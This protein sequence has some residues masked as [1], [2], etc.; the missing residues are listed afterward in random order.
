[1]RTINTVEKLKVKNQKLK[2]QNSPSLIPLSILAFCFLN[3]LTGCIQRSEL[4]LAQECVGKSQVYYQH[5][6]ERYKTLISKGKDL[7]RLHFELGRLYFWRGEFD[8]AIQEL[9]K[10]NFIQARKLLAVSYY[11]LADFTDALEVF[12][13]Q[14]TGDEEYLYYYGLTCEKLNL[15]DEALEVYKKIKYK[16][17]L[18]LATSRINIIEKQVGALKIKDIDPRVYNII[19]TAPKQNNYPQAGALIL[20]C[21]EK[22]EI[23]AKDTQISSLHYIVK[24]LNERGKEDFSEAHIE[25]DSTYEK[26]ELEYART[27]KPD[28]TVV[29]VGSRHIRDVSKYL[30]FPLYSN[31]RV[32]I[33]S[34]PEIAESSCID[35]KLKIHRNQ[36]INKKDFIV[37][38]PLE[39]AEPIIDAKFTLDLPASKGLHLKTLNEEYNDFKAKLKPEVKIQG[40]RVIYAWQF[41]DIPQIIPEPNMPA[42]VEINPAILISSFD[43]W[44]EVYQWWLSL[45][46]EKI[47]ADT[48]IKEKV[49]DLIKGKVSQEDKARSIYNFCAKEIRYVA[50]EY[51]Q[52]GY[53]PHQAY[54]IFK[55]KYGDC[56]DQAILLVTMLR[57]AGLKAWPVLISTK[58]YYNLNHDLPA[59]FFNHSIACVQL[60]DK[61]VFLDPTCSTCSFGDLPASDQARQ[62]LVFKEDNY[63]IQNGKFGEDPKWFTLDKGTKQYC[64]GYIEGYEY[65]NQQGGQRRVICGNMV[66]WPEENWGEEVLN[67]TA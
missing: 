67:K 66:V 11:W 60:K 12:S 38:Y 19:Q 47:R 28:G 2:I 36:L 54:D 64:I 62:V 25:Y 1:M 33:I 23:T 9:K 59:V 45:A 18:L 56:K 46:Q 35:Y 31:A 14:D 24:I 10:T 52:A 26:V 51:G 48:A 5:A 27:I 30:N 21:D 13:K 22:V 65:C 7:D 49:K 37:S 32:F 4:E 39:S 34:F 63:E 43:S 3:L 15:F 41:K 61:I 16:D 44:K 42:S 8:K 50:V 55:N 40:D 29:E 20:E 58:E 53:E 57:E 17:F 6:V